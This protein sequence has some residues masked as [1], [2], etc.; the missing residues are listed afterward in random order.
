LKCETLKYKALEKKNQEPNSVF[1]AAKVEEKNIY[2]YF[3][4]ILVLNLV[5]IA[6]IFLIAKFKL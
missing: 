1:S 3:L 5:L 4:F 6:L 2:I